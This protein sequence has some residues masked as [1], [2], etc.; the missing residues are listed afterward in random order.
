VGKAEAAEDERAAADEAV[1]VE[2]DAD[3]QLV[4]HAEPIPR[5]ALCFNRGPARTSA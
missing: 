4:R 1:E 5:K 2:A 3:A